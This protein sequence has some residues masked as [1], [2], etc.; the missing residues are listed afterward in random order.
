MVAQPHDMAPL[1]AMSDPN[2]SRLKAVRL[3]TRAL[4]TLS[5]ELDET[6]GLGVWGNNG[7]TIVRWEEATQPVS[8]NLQTGLVLP[9]LASATGLAFAAWLPSALTTTLIAQELAEESEENIVQEQVQLVHRLSQI[10]ANGMVSITGTDE[11]QD[12]YGTKIS[13]LSVPVFGQDGSMVL[14]L[15][16]IGAPESLD[17]SESSSLVQGLRRCALTLS[18]QLGAPLAPVVLNTLN[19]ET[20]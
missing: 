14:A 15:T 20:K 1:P 2:I 18:K 5:D 8:E 17:V 6:L 10:R 19:Q 13:A 9:I 4:A 7:P 12:L 3:A 11:F 16:A